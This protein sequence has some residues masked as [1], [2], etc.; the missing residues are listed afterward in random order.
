M[1]HKWCIVWVRSGLPIK[2][3]TFPDH[4]DALAWLRKK[5]AKKV[6]D[7]MG[8]YAVDTEGPLDKYFVK[9]VSVG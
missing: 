4:P 1:P 2:V 7:I 9:M 8:C 6:A 5:R 3:I